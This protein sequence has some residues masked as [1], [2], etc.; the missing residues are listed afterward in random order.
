MPPYGLN[1]ADEHLAI[2][3]GRIVLARAGDRMPLDGPDV[4]QFDLDDHHRLQF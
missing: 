1:D 3:S 2:L 4:D